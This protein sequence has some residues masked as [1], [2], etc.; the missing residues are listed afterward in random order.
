MAD[1]D[2]GHPTS[3]GCPCLGDDVEHV[4]T[5]AVAVGDDLLEHAAEHRPQC[6]PL[7]RLNRKVNSAQYA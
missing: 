7:R 4:V 6:A 5:V 2:G 1:M 3:A